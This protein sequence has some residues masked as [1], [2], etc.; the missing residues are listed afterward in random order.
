M[1]SQVTVHL[2]TAYSCN[3]TAP[4]S[5]HSPEWGEAGG[6]NAYCVTRARH[7]ARIHS[8]SQSFQAFRLNFDPQKSQ[9]QPLGGSRNERS[10]VCTVNTASTFNSYCWNCLQTSV[11]DNQVYHSFIVI[12]PP[13]DWPEGPLWVCS[14]SWDNIWLLTCFSMLTSWSLCLLPGTEWLCAL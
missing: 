4:A 8:F 1:S 2:Q 7:N 13:L 9:G 5:P 14:Y 10:W 3:G 11:G 12:F 6:R